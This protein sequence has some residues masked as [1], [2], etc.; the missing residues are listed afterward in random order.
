MARSTT[1]PFSID[2]GAR[3][4]KDAER[5]SLLTQWQLP[6]TSRVSPLNEAEN[7]TLLV[8]APDDRNRWVL[9]L[10][11]SGVHDIAVIRSEHAWIEALRR[12]LGVDTPAVVACRDGTTIAAVSYR[13][14]RRFAAL[15]DYAD[16]RQPAF[17]DHAPKTFASLGALTARLHRHGRAWTPPNGFRRGRWD[18]DTTIGTQGRWGSWRAA[19]GLDAP[20]AAVIERAVGRIRERLLGYGAGTDRFGLIHADLRLANLLVAGDRL[21][22]IDFDDCGFGWFLYDF[23]AAVSFHEHRPEIA[24][25]RAAWLAAYRTIAPIG[26]EDERMLPVFILLRRVLLTAWAASHAGAPEADACGVEFT[27]ATVDLAERFLRDLD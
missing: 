15:F 14:Q 18:A 1:A 5:E 9:R 22:V 24:A 11:R 8:E 19:R 10:Y 25:L 4:C 17:D 16:G 13:G 12:D 6:P 26:A 23:A 7:T 2:R 20:G 3:S 21:T 27:R